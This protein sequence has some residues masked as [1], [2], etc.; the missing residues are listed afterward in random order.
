M[1]ALSKT[2]KFNL[3][4]MCL[5]KKEKAGNYSKFTFFINIKNFLFIFKYKIE[6]KEVLDKVEAEKELYSVYKL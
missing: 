4:V 1:G 6:I 3:C 5:S 2:N